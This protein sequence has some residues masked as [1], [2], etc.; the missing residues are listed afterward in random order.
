[1]KM[2]KNAAKSLD[3]TPRIAPHVK[4][5]S[6]EFAF[7]LRQFY[8]LVEE[9][10]EDEEIWYKLL[11]SWER[12]TNN[13]FVEYLNDGLDAMEYVQRIDNQGCCMEGC[14]TEF[15]SQPCTVLDRYNHFMYNPGF[16][17]Y[18]RKVFVGGVPS[19]V[20]EESFLQTFRR[21]GKLTA[22]WPSRTEAPTRSQ[23]TT[24]YT[25][26]NKSRSGLFVCEE[27]DSN[28][29][30]LCLGYV[31]L[32]YS[33]ERSVHL[34]RQACIVEDGQYFMP[35]SGVEDPKRMVQVRPWLLSEADFLVDPFMRINLRFAVFIGGVP[36][37][38]RASE[39]AHTMNVLYGNVVM[40][41]IDTDLPLK[42]PKGA[43]RVVFSDFH[44]YMRAISDRFVRLHHGDIDKIVE[45]KP[46]VLDDQRCDECHGYLTDQPVAPFFCPSPDCLQYYCEN[47]WSILHAN[48][49]RAKHRPLVKEA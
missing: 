4:M 6:R 38:I 36:R 40:A 28:R 47:C 49:R 46:Y 34:L 48:G 3:L 5:Y 42:Y 9:Q 12:K 24:Y 30:G 1:M 17:S 39:L 19:D 15:P 32:I 14:E 35:I 43:G 8:C 13:S 31:F 26:S 45:I 33:E 44:S 16:D 7:A 23:Q 2:L 11:T 27:C 37:P 22:D 21:F 25:S 41:G 10:D 20:N 18:S 29:F